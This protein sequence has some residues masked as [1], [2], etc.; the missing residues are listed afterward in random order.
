MIKI[1]FEEP[2]KEKCDCCGGIT[3][4]LTRF[5]Y[6]DGD[7]FA[8]YYAAFSD[9]HPDKEIKVAIG[10]GEWGEEASPED[11]RSFALTIRDGG[12]QY[13]VIVV[14]ANESPWHD[15]TFIGRMLNRDEALK[16]SWIEEVFHISD[17]ILEDDP[18]V[19]AYF[20]GLRKNV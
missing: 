8:V 4:R 17:H 3:T 14:D 15:A 11:R 9:N 12:A 5:V 2:G 6:K 10:M 13:E 1:E 20:E 19:K 7:A 16:H 18:E